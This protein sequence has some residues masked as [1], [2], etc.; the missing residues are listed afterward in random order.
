MELGAVLLLAAVA[1]GVGFSWR[2]RFMEGRRAATSASD[3]ELSSLLAGAP[4]HQRPAGTGLRLHLGK[5]PAEAYPAQREE[6]LRNGADVL[7]RIDTLNVSASPEGSDAESRIEAAVAVR[8]ADAA[9]Q[10]SP[11][12]AAAAS[13]GSAQGLDAGLAAVDDEIESRVAARRS[14]RKDKSGGFCPNCGKPVLSSDR[15]CP[16]CGICLVK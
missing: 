6:L 8:R 11:V 14:E 2:S 4:A 1:I 15:F 13:A 7:R 12:I 16:H 3:Q 9:S 5:I 10:S